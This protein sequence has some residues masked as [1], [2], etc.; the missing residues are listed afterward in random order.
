MLGSGPVVPV[1]PTKDTCGALP[2]PGYSTCFAI[3][4]TD[5]SPHKG[6]FG[7]AQN[8]AG[9][10]P[11]DLRHYGLDLGGFDACK[12]TG[13]A[14]LALDGF[15]MPSPQRT[16]DLV[17][18]GALVRV[19]RRSVAEKLAVRVLDDRV[20][21]LDDVDVVARLKPGAEVHTA[22]QAAVFRL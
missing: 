9:Y 13:R 3:K 2:K 15:A 19:D 22:A 11:S 1:H 16:I 6:L 20:P 12:S 18:K 14:L 8:P 17:V 7:A 10:G 5:V 21:A 4:R